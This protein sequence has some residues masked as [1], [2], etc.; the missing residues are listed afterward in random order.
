MSCREMFLRIGLPNLQTCI[1]RKKHVYGTSNA[2]FIAT[3]AFRP[4]SFVHDTDYP[5]RAPR[6]LFEVE[7]GEKAVYKIHRPVDQLQMLRERPCE[8]PSLDWS[9]DLGRF[10]TSSV[11]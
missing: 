6:I 10:T 11:L 9:E 8:L 5:L 2:D 7:G 1:S 3:K 4:S